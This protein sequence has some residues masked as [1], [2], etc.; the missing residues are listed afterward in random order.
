MGGANPQENTAHLVREGKRGGGGCVRSEVYVVRYSIHTCELVGCLK[1]LLKR[2]LD[3]FA[4][5][6][7]SVL[8]D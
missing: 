7:Q 3:I 8:Q 6:F 5:H 4:R 1:R 2:F